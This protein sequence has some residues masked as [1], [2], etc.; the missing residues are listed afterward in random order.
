MF[1]KEHYAGHV[2]TKT[3]SLTITTPI[4][5]YP[6]PPHCLHRYVDILRLL[7][8]PELFRVALDWQA[9][10]D[11]GIDPAKDDGSRGGADTR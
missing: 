6:S 5:T 1:T 10:L 11:A 4:I 7:S 9:E 2:G 3:P 8:R